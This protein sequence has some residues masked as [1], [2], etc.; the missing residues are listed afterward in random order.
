MTF[1]NLI[2]SPF[3]I[4]PQTIE[5]MKAKF[6]VEVCD[7][8]TVPVGWLGSPPIAFRLKPQEGINMR[9]SVITIVIC[10]RSGRTSSNGE[11][12]A[13]SLH[14]A[15]TQPV[16]LDRNAVALQDPPSDTHDCEKHHIASWRAIAK[17]YST[18]P[19]I[20]RDIRTFKFLRMRTP[21]SASAGLIFF[22]ICPMNGRGDTLIMHT[23]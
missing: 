23:T 15:T 19:G 8:T 20:S 3:R 13:H 22:T 2:N 4:P 16:S 12:S 21:A 1:N 5:D 17:K 6:R 7:P 11:R 14:W 10:A 18:T 9:Q